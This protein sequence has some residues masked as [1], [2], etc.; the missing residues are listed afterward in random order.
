MNI[1]N[2]EI[3]FIQAFLQINDKKVI[4]ELEE[5]LKKDQIYSIS[6]DIKPL[7]IEEL[8]NRIAQSEKDFEEGNFKTTSELLTKY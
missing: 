4:H 8:N 6:K 5:V 3:E 2:R 1:Q 7:S